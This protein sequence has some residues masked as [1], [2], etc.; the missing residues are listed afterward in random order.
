MIP[1]TTTI[2]TDPFSYL[3]SLL[4]L[5]YRRV[6]GGT[7]ACNGGSVGG[8]DHTVL[9]SVHTYVRK[10]RCVDHRARCGGSLVAVRRTLVVGGVGDVSLEDVR[11]QHESG[12][13]SEERTGGL[14]MEELG[15]GCL[16][17]SGWTRSNN[18]G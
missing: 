16:F 5:L 10:A 17:V 11:F 15:G 2:T 14:Y 13:L 7:E 6:V 9:A 18:G 8:G 4:S 3:R 1:Y 12:L